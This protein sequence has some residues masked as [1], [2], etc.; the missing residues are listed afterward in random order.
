[1]TRISVAIFLRVFLKTSAPQIIGRT[2]F[3]V[4]MALMFATTAFS[5]DAML[6]GLPQIAAEISPDV[7]AHAAWVLTAFIIGLGFGTFF[8]GPLSDAF[9]R[10]PL[11]YAGCIIYIAGAIA[12]WLTS[13]L[14]WMLVARAIQGIG[15]SGP[16]IVALAIIRDLYEGR[17]MARI[18]SL[19]MMIFILVPAI[20][21]ALGDL[22][23]QA[24]GWRA[25][26]G[27]FILFS[28]ATVL[29]VG[30]RL[31]EPLAVVDRRPIRLPLIFSAVREML[32]HRTVFLS[33]MVQ[34]LVLSML[35][36]LLTMIQPIYD[37]SYDRGDSFPYWFGLIALMSGSASFLNSLIVTRFGMRAVVT[38]TF[39]MQLALGLILLIL[40]S[41]DTGFEFPLFLIWQFGLFSMAGLT[42]GNLNAIA[43]EPMGHIAGM[44]ASVIGSISTVI[45][46]SIASPMS[47]LFDGTPLPLIAIVCV[48]CTICLLLM[49]SM[50]RNEKAS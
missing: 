4:L 47:L 48:F 40:L 41:R 22:I 45:G 42:V 37:V 30:L 20:A 9:G 16:R 7:P 21:P 32:G 27:F 38:V 35:F 43:M 28:V 5:I 49:Q 44:A 33:I 31:N 24:A 34:T 13:S 6:P 26:F 19:S 23:I 50:N 11:I 3:I 1:V 12:A 29:W 25:I 15:A 8:A 36:M 39:G 17:Q 2:E 46:A 10:K 14:E 18:V